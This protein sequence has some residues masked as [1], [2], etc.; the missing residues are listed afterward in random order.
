[1]QW[2]VMSG[3][4]GAAEKQLHQRCHAPAVRS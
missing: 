1:V 3:V 4:A 2:Y